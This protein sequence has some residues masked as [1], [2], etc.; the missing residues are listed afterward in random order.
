MS[1]KLTAQEFKEIERLVSCA[2]S[3][4][5]KKDAEQHIKRLKFMCGTNGAKLE[6]YARNVFRELIGSVQAASGKVREKDHWL[7]VVDQDLYKL[8]RFA[9]DGSNH[10]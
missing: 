6:P 7:G 4:W 10:E 5:T 8:I 3:A 9:E 1:E 2:T